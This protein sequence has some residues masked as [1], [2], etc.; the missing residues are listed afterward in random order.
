MHLGSHLNIAKNISKMAS[1]QKY[2][3]MTSL[4]QHR[5]LAFYW[6]SQTA[7][8][9][10]HLYLFIHFHRP[11][12]KVLQAWADAGTLLISNTVT[13]GNIGKTCLYSGRRG[14]RFNCTTSRTLHENA[15]KI[16]QYSLKLKYPKRLLLCIQMFVG[17]RN[18]YLFFIQTL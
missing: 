2:L 4:L 3:L 12:L 17:Q 8:F 16:R 18:E 10:F 1:L 9:S 13:K 11:G 14:C 5:F 15:S 6:Q 7:K